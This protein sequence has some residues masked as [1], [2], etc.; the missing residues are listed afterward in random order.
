MVCPP[1]HRRELCELNWDG[2][3]AVVGLREGGYGLASPG[4]YSHFGRFEK[5]ALLR[6]VLICK[7][8]EAAWLA[9]AVENAG[10]DSDTRLGKGRGRRAE[11]CD[12]W[13]NR[14][15]VCSGQA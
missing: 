9:Q 11:R 1:L 6:V 3:R 7:S 12:A 2:L 5:E 8:L 14:R 13:T 15:F 10:L 4:M